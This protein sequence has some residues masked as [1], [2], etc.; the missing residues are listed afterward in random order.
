MQQTIDDVK[1]VFSENEVSAIDDSL[2]RLCYLAF[3]ARRSERGI[4]THLAAE[5]GYASAAA[6]RTALHGATEILIRLH[7]NRIDS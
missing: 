1:I 2:L 4:Y 3:Q 5:Y 6:C 7:N